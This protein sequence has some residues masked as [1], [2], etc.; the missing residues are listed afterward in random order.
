[1]A[2]ALAEAGANVA[3]CS[4]NGDEAASAAS[5]IARQTGRKALGVACDVT[6]RDAVHRMAAECRAAI[7][8]VDI[9]VNNAGINIRKPTPEL[10]EADWDAVVDISVKGAFFCAQALMPEMMERKWGRIVMLGST[11]SFVSIA[12]RSPYSTAKSGMLGLTR[13][14]A[15]EGA[16]HGVTV[17]CLCPGPFETPMNQVLMNDPA[18]YQA[19]IAKVPVGRWAQP[20]ELGPAIVYLCS[21][22]SAFVTGTSLTIDG[23]WTAQ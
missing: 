11:L 9:L 23:G 16:P 6:D 13:A 4:R 15:L 21:P 19:F 14:L 12:G 18:V 10:S 3:V 1:M 22:G 5:E 17:N 8:P 2:L 20:E 7:G